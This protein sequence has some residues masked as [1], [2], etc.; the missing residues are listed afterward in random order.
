MDSSIPGVH[1][2]PGYSNAFVVDG[3]EGVTLIDTGL[4]K[5]H[6][7]VEGV[8]EGIGRS[9]ADVRAIAITHAH[10]DHT[11]GAAALKRAPPAAVFASAID[12]PVI[13]GDKPASPP[14][15]LERCLFLEPLF[16]FVPGAEPLDVDYEIS[17]SA[18]EGLPE[19]LA[20]I[21]TPVHTRGHVCYLLDRAG[22]LLLVGD[23]A[24][25]NRRGEVRRGW[26]NAPSPTFDACLRHLAEFEFVVALFAHSRAI[27]TGAAAFHAFAA[28]LT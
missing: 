8:L 13:R 14:P 6:G 26:M 2:V 22:G 25:A 21:D 5:K 19:D 4:S 16:R 28:R 12:A 1:V 27:T 20:V 18:S 7:A 15:M 10:S 11:G 24:V 9:T 17:E 23:A 3:D